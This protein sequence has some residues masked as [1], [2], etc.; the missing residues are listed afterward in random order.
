[1]RSSAR[2]W[3]TASRARL[4]RRPPMR[5]QR[6][7]GSFWGSLGGGAEEGRANQPWKAPERG[8]KGNLRPE[9]NVSKQINTHAPQTRIL[10][11]ESLDA[12][13]K[14]RMAHPPVR[15]DK[16]NTRTRFP[17]TRDSNGDFGC[18]NIWEFLF[19]AG[20]SPPRAFLSNLTFAFCFR[21][22][23]LQPV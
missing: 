18:C 4:A 1:M 6:P 23:R 11:S 22:L 12:N 20:A 16:H 7:G 9:A 3:C 15:A 5:L 17:K 21:A 8:A 19:V 10:Q 13:D 14:T 2:S